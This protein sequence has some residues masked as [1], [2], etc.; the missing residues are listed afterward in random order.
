MHEWKVVS[1]KNSRHSGRAGLRDTRPMY[2]YRKGGLKKA[3]CE[4]PGGIAEEIQEG[5][6]QETET[7]DAGR[8]LMD[9]EDRKYMRL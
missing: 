2:I 7:K 5:K 9:A 8:G 6:K 4:T 3:L 1:G